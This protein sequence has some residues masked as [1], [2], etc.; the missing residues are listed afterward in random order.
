M[1]YNDPA[2]MRQLFIEKKLTK[3]IGSDILQ[4]K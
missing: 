2:M 3:G 4:K 1:Y